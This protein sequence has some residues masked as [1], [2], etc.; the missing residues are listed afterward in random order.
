MPPTR[1]D[2][3]LALAA[4]WDTK[5]KQ[6]TTARIL[7]S[8]AEGTA[9]SVRAA[10]HFAPI[11]ALLARFFLDAGYPPGSIGTGHPHIVLPGMFRPTKR[12]DLAVIHRS[13]LV[14]AIELKGIGGDATSIGRNYNNRLE[15]AL[16]N[17][18]DIT[19]ADDAGL[20][21]AE[22]PWLGYFFVMEDTPTS[23]ASKRPEKGLIP[24]APEWNG[25][26]HQERFAITAERL[27]SENLYDAVCYLTS[28]PANPGPREPCPAADWAHFTAAIQ[29]RLAY[30]GG[31]GYP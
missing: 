6:A 16:G 27:L 10:G 29:A 9:K 8:T 19:R 22:R 31:L 3:Q 21:G 15:E 2:L 7:G 28:S 5:D 20:V 1:A 12:W 17:S 11:A 14:A 18:L 25:L 26:S 24:A 4:Y 30:L 23:R 13:V